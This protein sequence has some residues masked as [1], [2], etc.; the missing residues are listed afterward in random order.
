MT[1]EAKV[2]EQIKKWVKDRGGMC[3]KIYQTGFSLV[4]FPDLAVILTKGT[5]FVEVKAAGKHPEPIQYQRI[6]EI[7]E[8]GGRAFW[9][10]SLKS[11]VRQI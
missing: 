9:C 3:V 5:Y 6:K 1:P 2:I 4:G 10:D 11:F 8:A 7:N